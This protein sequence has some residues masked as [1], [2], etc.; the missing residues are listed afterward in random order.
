MTGPFNEPDDATPLTPAGREGLRPGWIVTRRDLNEV[1]QANIVLGAL[2]ARRSRNNTAQRLLTDIFVRTLH[3]RMF[4]DVWRRAG[5]YGVPSAISASRPF[6]FQSSARPC[7]M[8]RVT[9]RSITA[10]RPM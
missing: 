1:E 7:S 3:K 8:T 4:D 5:S 2:W 10:T 6:V 9:G